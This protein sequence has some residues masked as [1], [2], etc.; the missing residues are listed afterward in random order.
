MLK[1]LE[2]SQVWQGT[3]THLL[4][5]LTPFLEGLPA[6]ERPRSAQT[7]AKTL[8]RL[9]PNLS[10]A[11]LQITSHRKAGGNR[12]RLITVERVVHDDR[13]P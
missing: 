3:A 1:L 11:G 7:L 13:E 10:K 2:H 12:D 6:P 5:V 4:T 9:E 8:Q